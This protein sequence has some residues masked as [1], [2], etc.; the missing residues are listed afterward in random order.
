MIPNLKSARTSR[1]VR[2]TASPAKQNAH[3]ATS[4]TN[5]QCTIG[6]LSKL[7]IAC[8]DPCMDTNTDSTQSSTCRTEYNVVH[9]GELR[10]A[11]PWRL[12]VALVQRHSP[13]AEG[14][15]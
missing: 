1:W 2:Y 4:H 6:I 8:A 5:K 9:Q 14:H 12:A 13:L 3:L 10:P 7:G 15:P 11:C